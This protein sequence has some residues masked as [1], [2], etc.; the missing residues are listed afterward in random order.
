M[1]SGSSWARQQQRDARF[2]PEKLAVR[3]VHSAPPCS[4][5]FLST[6]ALAAHSVSKHLRP[7][8]SRE[9]IMALH[10]GGIVQRAAQGPPVEAFC[11]LLLL[12]CCGSAALLALAKLCSSTCSGRALH[13]P[14]AWLA[15]LRRCELRLVTLPVHAC[16]HQTSR[17]LASSVFAQ[18]R[19]GSAQCHVPIDFCL[20][21][22]HACAV[23]GASLTQRWAGALKAPR[24][25]LVASG[26][27]T[28]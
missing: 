20:P 1:A 3:A 26:K 5:P 8:A 10:P 13:C 12:V 17:I 6:M 9:P 19:R 27:A 11:R 18:C 4:A 24:P 14:L 15:G 23:I 28:Q 25:L 16:E 21:L 7:E 2:W 22:Y